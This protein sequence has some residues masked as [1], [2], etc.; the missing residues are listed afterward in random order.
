MN[1]YAD[2]TQVQVINDLTKASSSP[3]GA[4]APAWA[5][6][7]L[8]AAQLVP[9][10]FVPAIRKATVAVRSN[11]DAGERAWAWAAMLD[12]KTTKD[13]DLILASC[14]ALV[15]VGDPV[16]AVSGLL[17]VARRIRIAG[18]RDLEELLWLSN[19]AIL[20]CADGM[21]PASG[22]HV[23]RGVDEW[24]DLIADAWPLVFSV[25]ANGLADH[26]D[27]AYRMTDG[28]TT[29]DEA[30]AVAQACLRTE[31]QYVDNTMWLRGRSLRGLGFA[32][33]PAGDARFLGYHEY[34]SV[35]GIHPVWCAYFAERMA[36]ALMQ[37]GQLTKALTLL[38]DAEESLGP[39]SSDPAALAKVLEAQGRAWRLSGDPDLGVRYSTAAY[40]V[41]AEHGT[42]MFSAAALGGHWLNRSYALRDAG[43]RSAAYEAAGRAYHFYERDSI[44]RIGR[45]ES[46]A[47]QIGTDGDRKRAYR[48]AERLLA[49]DRSEP[50]PSHV[51][52]G[53]L[54]ALANCLGERDLEL[55]MQVFGSAFDCSNPGRRNRV[56]IALEAARHA[57]RLSEPGDRPELWA[58]HAVDA[59]AKQQNPLMGSAAQL[60]LA[61]C[62]AVAPAS[63]DE[64]VAVANAGLDDLAIAAAGLTASGIDN[65]L[66]SVRD[67][68]RAIFD[69]AVQRDDGTLALRVFEGGRS[70]RLAAMMRLETDQLPPEIRQSLAEIA[71]ATVRLG[72]GQV[73]P[74]TTRHRKTAALVVESRVRDLESS[75]GTILGSIMVG[76][77]T[78]VDAVRA[79]FPRSH[80][81]GLA[82]DSN[83][84]RWVWWAPNSTLP[85]A[86][87]YQLSSRALRL[88]D[89]YAEGSIT[90]IPGDIT[91]PLREFLPPSILDA[92]RENGDRPTP[93]LL[94]P[95]GRLWHLPFLAIPL[96]V[97]GDRRLLHAAELSLTPSFRV[98]AEVASRDQSASLPADQLGVAGYFNPELAGAFNE[99]R[100]C[101]AAWGS[102]HDLGGVAQFGLTA[103]RSVSIVATHG[104]ADAGLAQQLSD[105][106][107]NALTAAECVL[108][109][110]G[111]T[112]ILGACHGYHAST[113]AEP[114]G[115]LTVISARGATWVVG[116]HQRLYDPTVGWILGRTYARLARGVDIFHALRDAQIAYLDGL[117]SPGSD[118]DLDVLLSEAPTGADNPW[119]WAL[120]ITGPSPRR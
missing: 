85:L 106:H 113:S 71:T 66:E 92:L 69:L 23:D 52:P 90:E 65:V 44:L 40:S 114:I 110:F 46:R 84:L 60:L 72:E 117:A 88:L 55:A 120:T 25:D 96:E 7:L 74:R 76:S 11:T 29:Y 61:H 115:M 107:G 3:P 86:G 13:L 51:R 43:D 42:E 89:G 41:I 98:A 105:H 54:Q 31:P 21:K 14:R 53:A 2:P 78:D 9:A 15:E 19:L 91:S 12:A 100:A 112:V 75:Y 95:T 62:L 73:G 4:E 118:Q 1:R 50:L 56:V 83:V 108:R 49:R 109:S 111:P 68:L 119:Y 58:R 87:S 30:L 97:G 17:G 32:V 67:D 116:G 47:V 70:V 38:R 36:Q 64:A 20:D 16:T 99:G 45:V 10:E 22:R 33:S 101:A 8:T 59:A 81:I 28:N 26:L 102:F 79:G 93:V 18:R 82:E 103:T 94:C 77:E 48:R 27:G 5:T 63:S 57:L 35:R 6:E 104:T 34:L 37:S 24:A 39:G 80:L